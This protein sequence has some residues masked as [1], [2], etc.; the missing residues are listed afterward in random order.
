MRKVGVFGGIVVVCLLAIYWIVRGDGG[1]QGMVFYGN[2]DIREVT[3]GFRV[4]GRLQRMVFEEGDYVAPGQVMAQ[5]E[6]DTFLENLALAKAQLVQAKAAFENAKRIHLRRSRLIKT[7]AVSQ[8]LYDQA[9]ASFTSTQAQVKTAEVE[10]EKAQTALNDTYI[11]APTSGY[12]LTRVREP[13]SVVGTGRT[14][15]TLTVDDP[16]WVRAFVDEPK[17]GNIHPG[18]KVQVFTDTKP[19]KPY[20]GH[21]GFIASQAEFTPKTVETAELRTDLVYRFRIVVDN[22]DK[23]LRQ[24][25][26][27]TVKIPL[28]QVKGYG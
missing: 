9:E 13:G 25:M 24:G 7:G 4:P 12:I 22:P 17:L 15:Y 1:G 6:Q 23:S 19:D 5:L 26:P 16:I 10:I 8:S 14:V 3:L 20:A 27:V 28:D 11:K 21:V 2:V 18:Q